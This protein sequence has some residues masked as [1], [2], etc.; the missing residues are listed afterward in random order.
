MVKDFPKDTCCNSSDSSIYKALIREQDLASQAE[1]QEIQ[2]AA[3][4]LARQSIINK[5]R[6][7]TTMLQ[8]VI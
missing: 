5:L 8:K 2:G 4:E 3:D 1:L 7:P 6:K